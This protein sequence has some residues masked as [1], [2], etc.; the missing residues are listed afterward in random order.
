MHRRQFLAAQFG[1]A[2]GIPLLGDQEPRALEV[3]DP[4]AT[5]RDPVE[6][7]W[8]SGNMVT[9]GP[10]KADVVGTDQKAI[11][12]AVDYVARLGGGTV[13]ILP[14]TYRMRNAV[15]LR[16]HVR[17]VGSGLDSV[18][19]KEPSVKTK[20]AADSD[21]YE[22]EVTLANPKGFEVGDGI[23]LQ[24]QGEGGSLDM[25][26]RTIVARTGNR[27]KL[28]R[29]LAG[30]FWLDRNATASTLFALFDGMHVSD[31]AIE[32]LALDG[33]RTNNEFLNGNFIGCIFL[34]ES[35]RIQIRG[36][37][38]RNFNGDALSWQVCHD[39]RVED[40]HCHDSAGYGMHAGSGSQRTVAV[41]N[42]LERN[43]I[44]FFFCWGVR[45]SVCENNTILDNHRF[46]V[47][48]GHKDTDNL[49]RKNE[50]QRSGKVG[51]LFRQENGPAFSP[52]RNRLE[53][54]RILDSGSEDGIAVKLEGQTHSVGIARNEIRETRGSAQRIGVKIEPETKDIRLAENR[55]DGFAQA[56]VDL[57]KA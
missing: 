49:I 41:K 36:V 33:N 42:R 40:C 56:V 50:I 39:V 53:D 32:N 23:H 26:K 55:I 34:R 6:P 18:L 4:R 25:Y 46:G 35:N 20:L 37:I 16:S 7:K 22:Q 11:Q 27:F 57:R 51:V 15:Y 1:L 52:N 2:A 30:N 29:M 19:I 13:R 44:G 5:S 54:N 17:I 8:E 14:G 45:W 38:A 3:T 28:D 43:D 48:I 21:W 31:I 12:A 47:S 24:A 10:H 9:V